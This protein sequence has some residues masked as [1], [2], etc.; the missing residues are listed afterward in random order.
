MYTRQAENL[1]RRLGKKR[2]SLWTGNSKGG[3]VKIQGFKVYDYV[4]LGHLTANLQHQSSNSNS[5]NQS[6]QLRTKQQVDETLK[7]MKAI[8]KWE[9]HGIISHSYLFFVSIFIFYDN[10]LLLKCSSHC[11]KNTYSSQYKDIP[12][13]VQNY[14]FFFYFRVLFAKTSNDYF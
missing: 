14:L 7:D 1:K 3:P 13:K 11:T 4:L 6:N 8:T 9:P 2:V 5:S 12:L 10:I